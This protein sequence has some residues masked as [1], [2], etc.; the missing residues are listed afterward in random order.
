[1]RPLG[2]ER[3]I[4]GVGRNLPPLS[5]N[6]PN[7]D[8]QYTDSKHHAFHHWHLLTISHG[9]RGQ[10]GE[11]AS[12]YP[13]RPTT[14]SQTESGQTCSAPQKGSVLKVFWAQ[15]CLQACQRIDIRSS[16]SPV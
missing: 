10:L 1:M 4:E 5:T 7:Q 16:G 14:K 12:S 2:N 11:R 8:Q 13:T 6:H 9:V 15:L 3:I